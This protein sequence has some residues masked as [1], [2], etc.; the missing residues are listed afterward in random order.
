[1]TVFLQGKLRNFNN[2]YKI[3]TNISDFY[4]SILAMLQVEGVKYMSEI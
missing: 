4:Y 1:M 3:L 2:Y